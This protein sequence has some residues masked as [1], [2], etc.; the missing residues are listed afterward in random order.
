MVARIVRGKDIVGLIRY[1]EKEKSS[2]L[3]TQLINDAKDLEDL[4]LKD[5]I[6]AFQAYI[7]LNPKLTKPTFHVSLNPDLADMLTD[8]QLREIGREYMERMHYGSQPYIIYKH[9]DIDRIH[10]HI[11]SVSMGLNGMAIPSSNDRFR[12][13]EIR[14]DLEMKFNLVKAGEKIKEGRNVFAPIDTAAIEYGKTDTKSAIAAVVRSA[15]RDYKVTSLPEFK[16]LLNQYHVT[17]DEVKDSN[18][19]EKTLGLFYSVINQ[20]GEKVSARIKASKI[21]SGVGYGA[22]LEKFSQDEKLIREGNLK[23]ILSQKIHGV[24]QVYPNLSQADFKA[25]LQDQGIQAVLRHSR[26]DRLYGITFIDANTKAVFK[27]RSLGK[28]FTAHA[29]SQRFTDASDG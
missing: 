22:L 27:G 11:I 18:N 9:E 7:N 8:D 29:L 17:L 19:P 3:Y 23:S 21:G 5:K 26:E 25:R 4:T 20:S 15:T 1:N 6:Q 28:E 10:I 14:K 13:E 12:S 16:T 24:L 2:I